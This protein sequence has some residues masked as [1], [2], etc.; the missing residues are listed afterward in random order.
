MQFKDR[1]YSIVSQHIDLEKNVATFDLRLNPEDTIYKAHF[2]SM[3][4]TPGVCLVQIA[5]ELFSICVGKFC[6]INKAKNVK[7]TAMLTPLEAPEIE[8]IINGITL[9]DC[10][11]H[12]ISVVFRKG[13]VQFAKMS[14]IM[15]R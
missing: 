7:F 9:S 11:E 10:D 3:P 12:P 1:L 15:R 2:P 13:N 6:R 14:L 8:A 5:Q 4:I